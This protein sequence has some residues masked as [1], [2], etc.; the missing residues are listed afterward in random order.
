MIGSFS[1]LLRRGGRHDRDGQDRMVDPETHGS[2]VVRIWLEGMSENKPTWRGHVQH[3]R[4]EE[5]CYFQEL[6]TMRK[7][8]ERLS[9][10]PMPDKAAEKDD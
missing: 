1:N 4:G 8:M 10:V 9:G 7:F 3:V 2:F 6:S 5:E